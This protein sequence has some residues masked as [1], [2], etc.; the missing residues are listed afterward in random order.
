MA[1]DHPGGSDAAAAA[2]A[3]TDAPS[4]PAAAADEANDK[5]DA[6]ASIDP[7]ASAA[8]AFKEGD[9]AYEVRAFSISL[10]L[11]IVAMTHRGRALL[12]R[13]G[14]SATGTAEA[15]G[16]RRH[17]RRDGETD[18]ASFSFFSLSHASLFSS[19]PSHPKPTTPRPGG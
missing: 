7:L 2:A 18:L 16:M 6:N 5:N 17:F 1:D 10:L 9:D 8:V 11:L 12:I 19:S 13:A 4:A 3:A 14:R 15:G